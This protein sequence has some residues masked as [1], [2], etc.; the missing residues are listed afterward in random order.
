MQRVMN[1]VCST[2]CR[3]ACTMRIVSFYLLFGWISALVVR[4]VC[5]LMTFREINV[6]HAEQEY[7]NTSKWTAF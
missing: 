4:I 1:G 2:A 7:N 6:Q 5:S 3:S